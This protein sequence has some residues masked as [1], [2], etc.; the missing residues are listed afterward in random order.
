MC[1]GDK[2]PP[3]SASDAGTAPAGCT[4]A[5]C[6]HPVTT[7]ASWVDTEKYCGDEVRLQGTVTP[8]QAD[9]PVTVEV[10]MNG[11]AVASPVFSSAPKVVGGT[12]TGT[13]VAKAASANWRTDKMTFKVSPPGAPAATSTNEFKFKARPTTA[14]TS[15]NVVHASSGGFLP[16]HEKH[17]AKLD[18][19][20]V[21]YLL[22]I[23]LTGDPFSAAKQTA[24][25]DLIQNT[26]NNG[27]SNKKFHRTGC[28]RG[29][30]CDCAFDCC[31]A[32]FQL[33]L[34]FV[35]S[36]EHLSVRVFATAAGAAPHRSGMN[37]DGGEW[38]DPALTPTTTYA[39]ETGH[40]LG[41]ADEYATGATDP[42]GVQPSTPAAGEENLM[43]TPGIT[44]LLIRHYRFVLKFLNDNAG[45]TY[46]TIQP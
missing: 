37:G 40:V 4:T 34:N 16:S 29:R 2:P 46:E 21:H 9:G 36:G 27:F 17:D 14:Y 20:K 44:R 8:P 32:G 28:K 41:Q 3:P 22:K 31:K 23:K 7:T 43:S 6:P 25:R 19:D 15:L 30:T 12:I 39:H 13:W 24:A 38:G 35:A 18:A 5:P 1:W 10:L 11:T 42:T 45:D 26:W 33:E